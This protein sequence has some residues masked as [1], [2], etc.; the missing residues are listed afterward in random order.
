[1]PRIDILLLM[2][3]LALAPLA[4]H[5]QGETGYRRSWLQIDEIAF[6]PGAADGSSAAQLRIRAWSDQTCARSHS[7]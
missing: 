2:L 3:A 4:A 5:R 1:M 7:K 6:A